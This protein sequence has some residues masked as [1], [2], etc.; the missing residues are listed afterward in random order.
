MQLIQLKQKNQ[1]LIFDYIKRVSDISRKLSNDEIDVEMTILR[2]MKNVSKKKQINFECQKEQ[3]YNFIVVNKLIK[4][5]YN[6]INKFNSFDSRYKKTMQMMLFHTTNFDQINDE[7]F[8]QILINNNQIFSTMFQTL[9]SLNFNFDQFTNFDQRKSTNTQQNDKD[10]AHIICY[11]CKQSNHYV[12]HC[13]NQSNQTFK[14]T[15]IINHAMISINQIQFQRQTKYS[16]AFN[17]SF[18][19]NELIR[20][21]AI[22]NQSFHSQTV[23]K[24][25]HEFRSTMSNVVILALSLS[26][27]KRTKVKNYHIDDENNNRNFFSSMICILSTQK[28]YL[29][30]VMTAQNVKS[31]Q[32]T[33]QTTTISFFEI[34][35]SKFRLN[36]STK[37]SKKNVKYV[38]NAKNQNDDEKNKKIQKSKKMNISRNEIDNDEFTF[39]YQQISQSIL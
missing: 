2:N 33:N 38:F 16:F 4:A 19:S 14:I 37:I 20:L 12:S 21:N 31:K 23:N 27:L 15:K 8:K 11:I 25:Q 17:Q 13:S 32:K 5:I 9:R 6:E 1:K 24:S 30:T 3:N 34:K 7:L 18:F 26:I 28:L 35:K 22:F 39:I 36:S 29:I 10:F